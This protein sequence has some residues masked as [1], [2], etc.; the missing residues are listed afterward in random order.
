M[1]YKIINKCIN[2]HLFVSCSLLFN[3]HYTGSKTNLYKIKIYNNYSLK[4][5]A[6]H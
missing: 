4:F 1:Q 5:V 2:E 6:T 3:N